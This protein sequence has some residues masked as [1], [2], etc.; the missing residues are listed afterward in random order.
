[1]VGNAVTDS[2]GRTPGARDGAGLTLT[3]RLNGVKFYST[4]TLFTDVV[5]WYRAVD[6]GRK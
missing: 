5:M 4:G 1:M 3:L 6:A 2:V